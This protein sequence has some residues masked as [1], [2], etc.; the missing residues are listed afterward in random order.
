[1]LEAVDEVGGAVER[2]DDPQVFSLVVHIG[3]SAR[4]LG[5]DGVVGISLEQGLDDGRFGSLVDV[6]HEIVMLFF[7]DVDAVEVE[8]GAVDDGGA[9]AGGFDRRIEHWVHG[10]LP[11]KER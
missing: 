7:S 8:R 1:M 3:G 4:F 5:Q 2:I 9:A 10:L 11:L 6:G